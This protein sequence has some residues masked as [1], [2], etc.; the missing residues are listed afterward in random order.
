[1]DCCQR[2][3]QRAVIQIREVFYVIPPSVTAIRCHVAAD[4]SA[5]LSDQFRSLI[6]SQYQVSSVS[7]HCTDEK[8]YRLEN[9]FA[10]ASGMH[11]AIDDGSSSSS[12]QRLTVRRTDSGLRVD[13]GA[14][15]SESVCASDMIN[16]TSRSRQT[17]AE[18]PTRSI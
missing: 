17:L 16:H 15:G 6:T 13:T 9:Q 12:W 11:A 7:Q 18:I 2:P 5:H 8:L 14:D 3:G 4:P 10:I 1:M